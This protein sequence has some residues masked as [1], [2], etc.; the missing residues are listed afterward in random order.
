MG[1]EEARKK[2]RYKQE[3]SIILRQEERDELKRA[4]R[5][6]VGRPL[7]GEVIIKLN[8]GEGGITSFKVV[9]DWRDS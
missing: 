8:L 5:K 6:I 4:V 3:E 7:T 1:N 2:V 9:E